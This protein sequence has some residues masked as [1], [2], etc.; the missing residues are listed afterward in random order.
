MGRISTSELGSL[1]VE[2]HLSL[3][4]MAGRTGLF[5]HWPWVVMFLI[6]PGAGAAAV[7]IFG[8][9]SSNVTAGLLAGIGV[10]GGLLFQVL[11]WVSGRIATLADSM[12][13]RKAT[14]YELG[15]VR[16]LDI[17]RANIA[18]ATFVSLV[19]VAGLGFASML[20]KTPRWMNGVFAFLLFHL[21]VTLVLVLLRINRI[22]K[23][24]RVS[25]LTAHARE[26]G[27]SPA[28]V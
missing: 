26:H 2:H 19:F 14:S 6:F 18:Y 15:L 21:S 28:S 22:G 7:A 24:D 11:A 13:A 12:G 9:L 4:T 3:P 27:D 23:N 8:H 10:L 20:D 5:R 16:R 1:F 17:A 25:A